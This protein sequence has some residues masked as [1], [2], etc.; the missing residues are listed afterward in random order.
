MNKENS[1]IEKNDISV[2]IITFN[3]EDRIEKTIIS[4]KDFAKEII[5][6]D[7]HS[8]DNTVSICENLGAKVFIEDWK[9]YSAQKNSLL[10]KCSCNWILFIDADEE[11]GDL[12]KENIVHSLKDSNDIDGF[13]IKRKTYYLGR[14][15][16]HS[17]QPDNRLRLVKKSS[18]PKWVGEIVHESLEVKGNIKSLEGYLVHYSYRNITD[19]FVKTVNYAKLSADEYFKKGRKPSIFKLFFNP[20]FAFIKLYIIKLGFLDGVPGFI[21]GVSAYVYAFLK[22]AFLWDKYRK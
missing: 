17:W 9:G 4:C 11:V 18:N 3:E 22:Y 2:A 5:V 1:L 8:T 13:I 21:A 19:H 20:S 6:I 7:S 10:E 16:N 14:L 15:L 12:L